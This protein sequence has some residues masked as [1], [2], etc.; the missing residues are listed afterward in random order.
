MRRAP[1]QQREVQTSDAASDIEDSLPGDRGERHPFQEKALLF[2]EPALSE[3]LEIPLR[4]LGKELVRPGKGGRCTTGVHHG[5]TF[6]LQNQ[7]SG[8]PSALVSGRSEE[9]R[10]GKECRSR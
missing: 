6:P 7:G 2:R 4:R 1:F 3:L 5:L 10:V 9:R 8:S